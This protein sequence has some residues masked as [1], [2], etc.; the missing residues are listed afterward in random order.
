VSNPLYATQSPGD[1]VLLKCLEM[2][3]QDHFQTRTQTWK[4]LEIEAI[5][6]LGLVGIDWQLNRKAA[7]CFAAIL[8]IVATGFGAMITR[9]H[10]DVEVEKFGNIIEIEERLGVF[11]AG[12]FPRVKRPEPIRLRDAFIPSCTNTSLFILRMH[13]MLMAFGIIYGIARLVN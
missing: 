1:D 6:A 5:L 13:L 12:L 9:R 2:E 3:W 11:A 10:R 8:L 7:T 4:T